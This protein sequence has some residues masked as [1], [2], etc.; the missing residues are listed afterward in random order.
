ADPN[1]RGSFGGPTH[2]EG[3]TALH[4]AAQ[5]GQEEAVSALLAAGADPSL[6]DELHGGTAA[7]W[8]HVGGHEE[9]EER[10][11]ALMG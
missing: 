4:V 10:L 3:V 8:A 5:S 6:Q 7:G 1:G 2:G 9:L 11:R